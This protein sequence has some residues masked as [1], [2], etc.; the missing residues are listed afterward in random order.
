MIEID[1]DL[2]E[3]EEE[4]NSLEKIP[5]N[6]DEV[7]DCENAEAESGAESEGDDSETSDVETFFNAGVWWEFLWGF[8][9]FNEGIY[10]GFENFYEGFEGFDKGFVESF[11][12]YFEAGF[13]EELEGFDDFNEASNW[14]EDQITNFQ[15]ILKHKF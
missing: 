7:W 15:S 8:E 1:A 6:F 9:G 5:I 3:D 13:D 4:I 14:F 2:I 12:E 11:Y 10:K